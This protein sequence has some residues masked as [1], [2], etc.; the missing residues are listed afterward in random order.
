MF[1]CLLVCLFV[2]PKMQSFSLYLQSDQL[3]QVKEFFG[4]LINLVHVLVERTEKQI[5]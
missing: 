4:T 5:R 2:C 3:I 1:V